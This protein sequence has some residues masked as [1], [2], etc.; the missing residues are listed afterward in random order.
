MAEYRLPLKCKDY[1]AYLS[2][3][4]RLTK[5]GTEYILKN[6]CFICTEK[7]SG[8]DGK[9][10]GRHIVKDPFSM[11]TEDNYTS[12]GIYQLESLDNVISEM[13]EINTERKEFRSKIEY[14][15]SE[16]Y[17]GFYLE[18]T[19]GN[20]L[21]LTIGRLITEDIPEN[22]KNTANGVSYYKDLIDPVDNM[23][24][25]GWEEFDVDTMTRLRDEQ[26]IP[27]QKVIGDRLVSTRLAR[28]LFVLAG[29]SRKGTPIAQMLRYV[30]L[31]SDQSDVAMLRCH[32]IYKCGQS[33]NITVNC[34]HEYLVLMYDGGYTN[35]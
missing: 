11:N 27:I 9:V 21:A 13:K 34:I 25:N 16:G 17:F 22:I 4:G 24:N 2:F 14:V 1:D 19:E 23:I 30:F 29:V 15:K 10:P 6:D 5:I 12:D 26:I 7:K 31:P 35:E 20:H 32:A 3:L 33:I 18:D 28:S 8:T